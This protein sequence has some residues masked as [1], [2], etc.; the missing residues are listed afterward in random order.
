MAQ[1]FDLARLRMSGDVFPAA[2]RVGVSA[3]VSLGAFSLS[4]NGTLAYGA[5]GAP[6]IQLVW[7][8]RT[9]KPTGSFGSPGPFSRFRLASDE[10]RIVFESTQSD[11]QD[12]WV[13]DSV[14]G[15][16]LS[17]DVRSRRGQQSDVVP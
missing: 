1:P 16:T 4:E 7:T 8:D 2:E 13:A 15:V 10:K 6:T 12:I 17:I 5:G 9:G 14:R 3:Y 11:N